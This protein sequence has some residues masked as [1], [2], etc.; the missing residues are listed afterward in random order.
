MKWQKIRSISNIDFDSD[1]IV[2]YGRFQLEM[3]DW[4][5]TLLTEKELNYYSKFRN[6]TALQCRAVL[7]LILAEY[8]HTLPHE[9]DIRT[10]SKG[11]PFLADNA[12]NF[13]VSHTNSAYIIVLSRSGRVGVDMEQLSGNEDFEA[14]ADYAFSDFEK[15]Q[16]KASTSK[17][18]E[19]ETIWTLKEAFLKALGVGLTTKLNQI[20]VYE[21]LTGYQ[22]NHLTF[23]CPGGETGSLVANGNLHSITFRYIFHHLF[24]FQPKPFRLQNLH[25]VAK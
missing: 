22:L 15:H 2:V 14:M 21:K 1:I 7:R 24:H 17:E 18:T 25:I 9:I 4:F 12:L 3:Q 13:N 20:N 5:C 11:K 10:T 23:I 16:L 6:K 19:F 8:C